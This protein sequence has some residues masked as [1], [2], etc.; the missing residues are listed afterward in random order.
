MDLYVYSDLYKN[1]KKTS[2]NQ[3]VKNTL[4]VWNDG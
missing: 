4:M 3:F 2:K 1:K